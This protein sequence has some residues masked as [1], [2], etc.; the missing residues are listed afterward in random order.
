MARK[1]K[2]DKAELEEKN[3]RKENTY[4]GGFVIILLIFLFTVFLIL[5]QPQYYHR[6]IVLFSFGAVLIILLAIVFSIFQKPIMPPSDDEFT[7]TNVSM[8]IGDENDE[9]ATTEDKF[10]DQG[11][12]QA[13][14]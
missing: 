3:E 10:G 14:D 2:K 11:N 7:G 12:Q 4:T 13:A 6:S 5:T 8:E 9:T 1:N